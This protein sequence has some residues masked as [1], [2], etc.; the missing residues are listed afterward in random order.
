MLVPR[1]GMATVSV[2]SPSLSVWIGS[3]SAEKAA[4]A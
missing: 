4:A 2:T 3:A 1:T